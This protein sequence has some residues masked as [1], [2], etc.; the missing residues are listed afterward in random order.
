M[1]DSIFFTLLSRPEFAIFDF[2]PGETHTISTPEAIAK[3]RH[4]IEVLTAHCLDE[5]GFDPLDS[6]THDVQF[7]SDLSAWCT[8]HVLPLCGDDPSRIK[9]VKAAIRNAAVL[10][11]YLYPHH[12][13]ISRTHLA[14]VTL[15]GIALDDFAGH[16]E[17]PQFGHYVF[18][19]LMGSE[20]ASNRGGWLGLF[21]KV[22]REYI[23]HFGET[24]PRAGVL[25]GE[26]LFQYISSL[27]NEKR[28]DGNVLQV[29]PHLR[30]PLA[31]A[32][33]EG[34]ESGYHGCC[35]SGYAR[36]LRAQSGGSAA[37]IAGLFH[38]VPFDYWITS[39]SSLLR[40]TDLVNDLMSFS[41]EVLVP[42]SQGNGN[43]QVNGNG[44]N[45]MNGIGNNQV[46]GAHKEGGEMDINYIT[47]QTL[48]RRQAG[49]RSRFGEVANH[50]NLYTSRDGLCEM[51]DELVQVVRE[52]DKAFV[53]YPKHCD[54]DQRQRWNMDQAA[55][56][57]TAY[58]NG[59][60]RMHIDAPRWSS[61]GLKAAVHDRDAW[62]RLKGRI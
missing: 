40:F 52:A 2:A 24:D 26:V 9:V 41:K 58:K 1:S 45:Q 10:S 19:I 39:L 16:D 62:A 44:N 31:S 37:Y 30:P 15:A 4:L 47:L 32:G 60:I 29:P 61:E 34:D 46:N 28:F 33:G 11:D 27:E 3:A 17:A 59:F 56:V 12:D 38:G 18:D 13:V 57:W 20:K 54:E 8:K 49:V 51:M 43:N 50:K 35:P 21:T 22:V 5:L 53:E 25:G 14:R 7:H 36:W 48:A 6:R 23:A 55:R 42:A